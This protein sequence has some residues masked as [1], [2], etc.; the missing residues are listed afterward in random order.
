MDRDRFSDSARISTSSSQQSRKGTVVGEVKVSLPKRQDEVG[1]SRRYRHTTTKS[2]SLP[3][4]C[5]IDLAAPAVGTELVSSVVHRH[6]LT[7]GTLKI[8]LLFFWH[9]AW[10]GLLL[11]IDVDTAADRF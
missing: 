8:A 9:R 2:P 6:V 7:M 5:P 10:E 3:G 4:S 1:C 11:I